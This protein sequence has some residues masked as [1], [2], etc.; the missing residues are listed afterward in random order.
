MTPCWPCG[1]RQTTYLRK[2][3]GV[4]EETKPFNVFLRG[5]CEQKLVWPKIKLNVFRSKGRFGHYSAGQPYY[6]GSEKMDSSCWSLY[7][8]SGF[9]SEEA[10]QILTCRRPIRRSI[11]LFIYRRDLLTGLAALIKLIYWTG[12]RVNLMHSIISKTQASIG[13][14]FGH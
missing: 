11:Q 1:P 3:G 5:F 2:W 9:L 13:P 14:F 6:N 4:C 12:V 10:Y 8:Y 7:S